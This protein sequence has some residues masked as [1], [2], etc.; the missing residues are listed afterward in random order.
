MLKLHHLQQSRSTR[1][2]WL[3]EEIG[4]DYEIEVIARDP[5]TFRAPRAMAEIDGLGKAPVISDGGIALGE[6]AAILDYLTTTRP[7]GAGFRIAPDEAGY[8]DYLFFLHYAEGSLAL[9]IISL[10]LHTKLMGGQIG[11]ATLFQFYAADARR[12]LDFI[13][14]K[15]ADRDFIAGGRFTA[16]DIMI[17]S[18]LDYADRVG[19]IGAQPNIT[20][21]K[22]RMAARPAF[23][24]A[25]SFG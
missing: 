23:L 3:V 1:I 9:P 16:A 13:E 8:A 19:L 7:E 2:I 20:A 21:Y 15:L 17:A 5:K 14:A 24:K 11:D 6:S 10:L 25:Q 12:H 18:M 22:Q 4:I